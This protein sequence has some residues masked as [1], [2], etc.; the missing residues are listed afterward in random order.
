MN[1]LAVKFFLV[2]VTHSNLMLLCEHQM[3]INRKVIACDNNKI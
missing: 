1:Q 3:Q 2:M